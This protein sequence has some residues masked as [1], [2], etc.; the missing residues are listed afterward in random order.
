MIHH[1]FR[2]LN[3]ARPVRSP[4]FRRSS[5][6]YSCSA[7]AVLVLVIEGLRS[8]S[9]S[10]TRYRLMEYGDSS[11]F[12]SL[13]PRPPVRSPAFRRSSASYSCSALAVLVLVIE[14]PARPKPLPSLY[15]ERF[16]AGF[17]F[18]EGHRAGLPRPQPWSA[19]YQQVSPLI[20]RS[21]N[22]HPRKPN[23]LARDAPRI[24]TTQFAPPRS[25]NSDLRSP[26]PCVLVLEIVIVL[27]FPSVPS[28]SSCSFASLSSC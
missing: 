19:S 9:G 26:I 27:A 18:D 4:A 25:P 16:L 22:R 6:S 14:G 1:R 3:H 7:L 17:R 2:L 11:P 13:E 20:L 28:A 15:A 24:P 12:S 5:A 23:G 8:H 21:A 10:P